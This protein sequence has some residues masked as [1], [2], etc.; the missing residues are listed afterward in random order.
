VLFRSTEFDLS[1]YTS[2]LGFDIFY[3][4]TGNG[5]RLSNLNSLFSDSNPRPEGLSSHFEGLSIKV[6]GLNVYYI[7]NYRHFSYPA[8]YSQSTV[9]RKSSGSFMLGF[10]FTH[11]RVSFKESAIKTLLRPYIDESLL[12]DNVKYNDYSLH[13]GYGYNY[14]PRRNWLI[15]LSLMPGLAYNATFYHTQDDDNKVK[16]RQHFP[17]FRLDKLNFDMVVRAAVVYNNSK[18]FAGASFILH[19]FDYRNSTVR[20]NNSFGSLNFYV[21]FN[22]KKK[23]I[24]P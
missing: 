16:E 17:D 23:K 15:N 13:A 5:F 11:H 19:S 24:R 12:F 20:L 21:G 9:Q 6:R 2:R 22:F 7:F 18:Y 14:V 1:I 4:D 8:A 3:R 10:S